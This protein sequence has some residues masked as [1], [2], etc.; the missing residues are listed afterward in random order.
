MFVGK[1]F[2]ITGESYTVTREG[3]KDGG[4]A[5]TVREAS[6]GNS[7]TFGLDFLRRMGVTCTDGT[8]F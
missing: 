1:S 4:M 5:V 7:E 8:K 6:T 2:K 3:F